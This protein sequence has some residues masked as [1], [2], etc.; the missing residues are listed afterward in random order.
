MPS[1]ATTNKHPPPPSVYL[2]KQDNTTYTPQLIVSANSAA[3][4][5][6][7]APTS[8]PRKPH[9]NPQNIHQPARKEGSVY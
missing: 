6:H 5:K 3:A 2:T 1:I 8:T 9:I 7:Q 4:T